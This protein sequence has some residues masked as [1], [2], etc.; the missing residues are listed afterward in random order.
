MIKAEHELVDVIELRYAAGEPGPRPHVHRE[1]A[2]AFY[3]LEG[4]PVF[5]LGPDGERVIAPAGTSVVVPAGV[6]H[7]FDNDGSNE[8][9]LLNVHAPSMRFAESLRA[10][11][12]PA[13]YDAARF[14]SFGPPANGGRPV[15]DAVVRGAGEGDAIDLG[16]SRA[17]FKAEGADGDGTL[18]LT[19]VPLAPG[20]AG[21]APHRHR[22]LVDSFYVLEGTVT[23]RL[24][25]EAITATAGS[26]VFVPPGNVHTFSNG[27]E[28]PAR[29]LN[30]MAP[31]GFE[32][33]LKE[34]ARASAAAGGP[35]GPEAMA[36]IAS[37]YDFH[38]A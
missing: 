23:V 28:E 1:H 33:Y 35:L 12:D 25:D 4:E 15:S 20:F 8:A 31:G 11:R 27:A 37:R 26:Y 19:E 6:I 13:S 34:V 30:L 29:L 38:P 7:G 22:T 21:P 18:S 14:D 17:L 2:D 36:A 5:R 9:R 3:V 32:Q 24:G 10:R 16:A